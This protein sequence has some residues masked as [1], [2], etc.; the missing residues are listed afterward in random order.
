MEIPNDDLARASIR[1]SI[2]PGVE[3]VPSRSALLNV[4][5]RFPTKAELSRV[6]RGLTHEALRAEVR[7]AARS[8]EEHLSVSSEL[9]EG[10]SASR[11]TGSNAEGA[12]ASEPG[13]GAGAMSAAQAICDLHEKQVGLAKKAS[14]HWEQLNKEVRTDVLDILL[15][16]EKALKR[17]ISAFG[18]SGDQSQLEPGLHSD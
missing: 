8:L 2:L 9:E 10:P 12:G 3:A 14:E 18:D 5:R 11:F 7:A 4:L 15:G 6:F 1:N 16:Y 13:Q 17:M